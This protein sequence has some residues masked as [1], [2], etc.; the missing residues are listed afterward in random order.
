MKNQAGP[1]AASSD[2][3]PTNRRPLNWAWL[4]RIVLLLIV[5]V[6]ALVRS[7]I[8]VSW[9]ICGALGINVVTFIA[10]A[11]DKSQARVH[12]WRLSEM[13]L[14]T[15]ELLGGW[16]G[17]LL[18]QRW[19]QHKCSKFRYQVGFWL[20]VFAHQFAALDSL[21]DWPLCRAALRHCTL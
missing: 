14:H 5:P 13:K 19:L 12:A 16:P 1:P 4:I 10:Y 20:I 11:H 21:R 2:S 3:A 9:L 17:A 8:P 18:A 7:G 15:L 6:L